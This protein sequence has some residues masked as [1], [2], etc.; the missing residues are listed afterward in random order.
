MST[1][2]LSISKEL[3]ATRCVILSETKWSK[4]SGTAKV[5]V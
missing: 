2:V 5:A 4:E 3:A 1:V